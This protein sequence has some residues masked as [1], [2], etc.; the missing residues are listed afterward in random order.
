MLFDLSLE[1]AKARHA[2]LSKDIE[3]HDVAYHQNDAPEISDADYDALRRELEQIEAQYPELM[4]EA[5][6]TK[7]VGAAP[8]RGFKKVK[9]SVPM[10]SLS[11]LFTEE[12]LGDFIQ[13]VQ[14]FLNVSDDIAFVAEPKIDGLSCSLRYEK[15]EL[16][17]AATRGD[18]FEGED[19]TANVRHI[20]D[21]PK[22]LPKDAPDVL[23]VRGEIY[24]RKDDFLA[25]NKKLADEG[26]QIL[27][28]PRNV[29]VSS[30][31]IL[32]RSDLC[33]S[34]VMPWAR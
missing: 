13:K 14:R 20:G 15:G 29:C 24:M 33:I 21:V 23:E 1:D 2:K 22:S 10:L 7:K 6:P 12:D 5:S 3:R 18:G 34:S 28:N 32:Q 25:L 17:Q 16:V 11:N 31:R 19:I 27:A 30:T 9:H 26:K 4:T 8:A